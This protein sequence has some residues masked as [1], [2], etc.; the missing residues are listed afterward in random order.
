MTANQKVRFK[1]KCVGLDFDLVSHWLVREETQR[2]MRALLDFVNSSAESQKDKATKFV[3]DLRKRLEESKCDK[4]LLR[5]V[6]EKLQAFGPGLTGPNLLINRY[7]PREDSLLYRFDKLVG[8]QIPEQHHQQH[9][10]ERQNTLTTLCE[11]YNLT[12]TE[13][14]NAFQNGFKQATLSGPLCNEEMQGTCFL[15]QQI[16]FEN[17]DGQESEAYGPF[18]G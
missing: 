14:F 9:E 12:A 6:N 18:V 5:L 3:E 13:V 7:L 15:I 1:V 10:A 16:S 11:Q 2:N 17:Q 4:L 8:N